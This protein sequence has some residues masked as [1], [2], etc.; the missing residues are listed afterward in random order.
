MNGTGTGEI[1]IKINTIDSVPVDG[2]FLNLPQK[3]GNYAQ[4]IS[5]NAS[6]DPDCDPTEDPCEEWLP[7]T[8]QVLIS[9]CNGECGSKHPHSAVYD[10]A[11]AN[12]TIT[13]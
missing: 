2:S 10:S 12:F 9:I 1:I 8:Y 6:P 5:I 13:N 11:L 4:K 7:G 3:P